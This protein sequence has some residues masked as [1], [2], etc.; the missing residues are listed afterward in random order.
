MRSYL[1]ERKFGSEQSMLVIAQLLEAVAHLERHNMAHRNITA[2]NILL[3]F[4][5]GTFFEDTMSIG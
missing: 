5:E 2:E 3:E 4:D 1:E